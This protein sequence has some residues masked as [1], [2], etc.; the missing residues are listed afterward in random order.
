MSS[1][2]TSS[3]DA[4]IPSKLSYQDPSL[5]TPERSLGDEGLSIDHLGTSRQ[6]W[7]A[8]KSLPIFDGRSTNYADHLIDLDTPSMETVLDVRLYFW[9]VGVSLQ[10]DA[11]QSLHVTSEQAKIYDDAVVRAGRL[12]LKNCR[13][14]GHG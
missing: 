14:R 4:A 5:S 2:G 10:E 8:D 3:F 7:G 9:Q 11:E 12:H 1:H 13:A 6:I